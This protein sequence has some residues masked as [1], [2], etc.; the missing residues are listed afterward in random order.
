MADWTPAAPWHSDPQANQMLQHM[1]QYQLPQE[2]WDTLL[3]QATAPDPQMPQPGPERR[4]SMW[5][6]T[7][8]ALHP[9]LLSQFKHDPMAS[10]QF[11]GQ[12]AAFQQAMT[13]K[14][15]AVTTLGG[16]AGRQESSN[17]AL[18][19]IFSKLNETNRHNLATEGTAA[20][21]LNEKERHNRAV[22]AE[23]RDQTKWQMAYDTQGNAY[24]APKPGA[25]SAPAAQPIMLPGGS[26]AGK[27]ASE[28][29]Q[30]SAAAISVFNKTMDQLDEIIQRR[31]KPGTTLERGLQTGIGLIPGSESMPSEADLKIYNSRRNDLGTLARTLYNATGIRA[32]QEVIRLINNIPSFTSSPELATTAMQ[33]LRDAFKAAETER[34]RLRPQVFGAAGGQPAGV[35]PA[36]LE[37]AKAIAE[38]NRKK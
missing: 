8:A 20:A 37:R 28:K 10:P 21:G 23:N 14:R 19:G 6:A 36:L 5:E 27:P 38:R 2:L 1:S 18:E 24:W 34:Q 26:Q 13:N 17:A 25:T 31:M 15:N 9:E 22:E 7:A 11:Q 12:M 30:E 35:D 29:E 32:Y 16:L 3:K 4:L 33:Q